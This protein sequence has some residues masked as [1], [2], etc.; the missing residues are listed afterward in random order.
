[1]KKFLL[2][3]LL[4]APLLAGG[5][6]A[7]AASGNT[8]AGRGSGT[9]SPNASCVGWGAS[10]TAHFYPGAVPDALASTGMSTAAFVAYLRSLGPNCGLLG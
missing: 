5:G 8:S 9:S 6:T 2:V 1:V 3:S 4:V 10:Q 7:H